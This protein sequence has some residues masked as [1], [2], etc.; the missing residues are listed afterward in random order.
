MWG[1]CTW[2]RRNY[3]IPSSDTN[4]FQLT[5]TWKIDI[6]YAKLGSTVPANKDKIHSC[7][8]SPVPEETFSSI[9]QQANW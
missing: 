1:F 5:N 4:Q 2:Y 3:K 6:S 7:R 8:D 9:L